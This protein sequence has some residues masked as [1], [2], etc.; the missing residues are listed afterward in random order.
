[1]IILHYITGI[2]LLSKWITD[3]IHCRCCCCCRR[4]GRRVTISS[5]R[6]H[7]LFRSNVNWT[8][9]T[10][11]DTSKR[12]KFHSSHILL[13][14]TK[15][16]LQSFIFLKEEHKIV[17]CFFFLKSSFSFFSILQLEIKV[18]LH[19]AGDG[20]EILFDLKKYFYFMSFCNNNNTKLT[21]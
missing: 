16:L 9:E 14:K 10:Y 15:L 21:S 4:G 13:G 8:I 12:N 3:G 5:I 2:Y 20:I 11:R 1:M 7:I 17:N 18:E 6:S 19:F